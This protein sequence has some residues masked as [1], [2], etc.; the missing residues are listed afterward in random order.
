MPQQDAEAS[1][2]DEAEEVLRVPLPARDE[3]AVVLEPREQSPR[4]QSLDQPAA[5]IAT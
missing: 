1:E 5:P 4:E 3:P 2:V